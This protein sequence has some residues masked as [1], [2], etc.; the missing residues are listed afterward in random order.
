MGL[1]QHLTEAE[2]RYVSTSVPW[3]CNWL[4]LYQQ[5]TVHSIPAMRPIKWRKLLNKKLH[6]YR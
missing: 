3:L 4:L 5:H 1:D 6:I 2:K